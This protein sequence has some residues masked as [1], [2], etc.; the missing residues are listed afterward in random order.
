MSISK[1]LTSNHARG[2]ETSTF[3]IF[4]GKSPEETESFIDNLLVGIH[5]VIE[6]IL[7]DRRYSMGV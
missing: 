7:V 6:M 5:L 2:L 1:S 4:Q 3:D